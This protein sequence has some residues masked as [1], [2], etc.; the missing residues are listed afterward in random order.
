[1]MAEASI[2]TILF[3]GIVGSTERAAQLGDQRWRELLAQHHEIVRAALTRFGGEEIATAG[4][5]FLALF[6]RPTLA[7][8]CSATTPFG[9]VNCRKGNLES[10]ASRSL[11]VI[12]SQVW[13]EIRLANWTCR[14][15]NPPE[16]RSR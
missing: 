1:M 9:V 2:A 3:T 5:G 8:G 14:S 12:S 6:D 11:A 16:R 7:I 13:I 15:I 10:R 4:D